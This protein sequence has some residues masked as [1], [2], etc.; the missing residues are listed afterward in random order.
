MVKERIARICWNTENWIYPSGKDGKS[1]QNR[2]YE[3]IVGFG[4]EEWL[5]DP[6]RIKDGYHYGF[7]QPLNV[8]SGKHFNIK[9]NI[10]LFT[11]AP[12]KQRLYVGCLYN[13]IG[14][15]PDESKE[16]YDYYEK[17][18]WINEMKEDVRRVGGT[19]SDF[20]PDAMFNVKFKM[21]EAVIYY[22]NKPII[23]KGISSNHYVLCHKKKE[24]EFLLD[25]EGKQQTFDTSVITRTIKAGKIDIIPQH[26]IIQNA[27]FEQLKNDYNNLTM[28]D[29]TLSSRQRVDMKGIFKESGEWH[30]FEVKTGSAK[31]SLREALGQILEYSHYNHSS[32]RASKLFIV[33]PQKPDDKD[34]AYI[35]KLRDM[36]HLPIWFRW[37]SFEDNKLYEE[38]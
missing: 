16:V 14:V 10:H 37:F 31:Q 12:N 34:I 27:I 3:K 29:S 24:F 36:Y 1:K 26:K 4:H 2:S 35:K 11:I 17:K 18:G 19:V 13:A 25:E 33:G 28:E 21:K 8:A 22:S 7:L 15:G 6:S 5:L 20:N 38:I 23:S 32:S 9:Y 30:F